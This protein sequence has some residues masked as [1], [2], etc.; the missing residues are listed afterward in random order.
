MCHG[1]ASARDMISEDPP[2]LCQS[3]RSGI[4][5]GSAIPLPERAIRDL[6]G[7]R[8]PS[9]RERAQGERQGG[10]GGRSLSVGSWDPVLVTLSRLFSW[11]PERRMVYASSSGS[12]YGSSWRLVDGSSRL[13]RV[14]MGTGPRRFRMSF[15]PCCHPWLT[16]ADR[17]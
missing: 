14:C 4:C 6:P 15:V 10:E 9:A 1:D 7:I 12:S 17:G 3:A 5:Q 13:A 2:S 8:H 11:I 16:E